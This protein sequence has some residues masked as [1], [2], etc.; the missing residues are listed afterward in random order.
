VH[1]ISEGCLEALRIPILDGR[2]FG[3]HDR[4]G[5]L[6]V[7]MIN[8]KMA[9]LFWPG[10]TA[11]GQ[12]IRVRDQWTTIV[13]VAGNVLNSSTFQEDSEVYLP[14][15]Q[16]PDRDGVCLAVRTTGN[17]TSV[18]AGIRNAVMQVDPSKALYDVRSMEQ[19]ISDS[20]FPQRMVV[21]LLGSLAAIAL[22]L[23]GA[24]IYGVM[25]YSV[26]RRT[27]ELGV[28]IALGATRTD[29]V[30][31]VLS[32]GLVIAASGLTIGLAAG[33]G[34][35]RLMAAIL[36]GVPLNDPVSF[37]AGLLILLMIS[38][39]A[40]YLPARKAARVDPITSLRHE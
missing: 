2:S 39:A 30:K 13:G 24:G 37:G 18:A 5:V 27:Q 26:T 32:G 7:A 38:L 16:Y 11:V 23:A 3:E 10:A 40:C 4:A 14:Y 20:T 36:Y 21:W 1:F 29:L 17:Q 31:T 8:Q 15:S 34:L 35:S 33:L 19:V 25:A 22:L 28:R 6:P 12:Q 9:G